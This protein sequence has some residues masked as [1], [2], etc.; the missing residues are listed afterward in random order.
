M[1]LGARVA[2]VGVPVVIRTDGADS[3]VVTVPKSVFVFL[4]VRGAPDGIKNVLAL[5]W[6]L[7]SEVRSNG[8][9]MGPHYRLV[10]LRAPLSRGRQRSS[11]GDGLEGNT[12]RFS[13]SCVTDSPFGEILF[14]QWSILI[15]IDIQN[16]T[17]ALLRGCFLCSIFSSAFLKT[18]E[19]WA[20]RHDDRGRFL[21]ARSFGGSVEKFVK[22]LLDNEMRIRRWPTDGLLSRRRKGR[23]VAAQVREPRNPLLRRNRE[24][25]AEDGESRRLEMIQE[26]DR[27]IGDRLPVD[28]IRRV[29]LT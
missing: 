21:T 3:R 6:G 28:K 4:L 20:R 13:I 15:Q 8:A 7:W 18:D 9:A 22:R 2:E 24:I 11:R 17:V 16:F 27:N 25:V 19:H 23:M 10:V 14:T 1:G 26:P 29:V 12:S 5:L